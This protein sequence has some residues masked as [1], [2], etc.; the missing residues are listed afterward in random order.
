MMALALGAAVGIV[1]G[2][3]G[4]GGG[5]LAV[6]LLVL[7]LHLSIAEAAPIGLAAVGLAAIVG[8]IMGL[9]R[10]IV[11]YKAAALM[12]I[13]GALAAPFG[14]WLARQIDTYFLSALFA[15][16]LLV[17]AIRELRKSHGDNA[18]NEVLEQNF[19][20][21]QDAA[22][23]KFIWNIRCARA[24]SLF[25]AVAGTLSGLLGVGGGFVLV[26]ALRRFTTLTQQS[27]IA[28][29]L[30]VIALIALSGLVSSVLTQTLQ[31]QH[32]VP[33]A[34]GAVAGLVAGRMYSARMKAQLLQRLFAVL[35]AGVGL[36]LLAKAV[37]HWYPVIA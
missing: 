26:P 10:G 1:M 16:L 5:I 19:A 37:L 8:A 21:V 15:C 18:D 24:L 13:S 14:L 6:P 7:V 12:A 4:T 17:L 36:M 2:L 34:A 33:F 27:V 28:T 31:W 30:A 25:G 9:R 20:C 32:A 11:R 22:K 35:V 29:S 3:T 23:G